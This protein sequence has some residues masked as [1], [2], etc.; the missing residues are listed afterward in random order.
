MNGGYD[1]GY[2]SAECVWGASPGAL[3]V[4]LD[5][6]MPGYLP[7]PVLDA[8]CGEGENSA[9]YAR[10]GAS[11][12]AVDVSEFAIEHATSI[13]ADVPNVSWRQDDVCEAN[14]GTEQFD[15]VIAYGLY[16][17]LP[18]RDKITRLAAKLKKCTKAG[19]FHVVCS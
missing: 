10:R 12:L 1:E 16:H 19:G 11:V 6:L 4:R 3:V 5:K 14:L 17:C 13:W 9:Y 8:G 15:L 2:R 18:D 7:A